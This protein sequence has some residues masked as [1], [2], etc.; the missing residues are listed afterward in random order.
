MPRLLIINADDLGY[1]PAVTTGILEAM[2]RGVVSSATLM[3][4]SPSSADAAHRARGRAVGL[5]LNLARWAPCWPGFPPGLLSNGE[6]DEANA[7]KLSAAVAE[8]ETLAQLDRFEAL[9]GA[10]PTHVDVH[11]HLHLHPAVFEGLC[12]AARLRALPVRSLDAAMRTRLRERQVRTCDAFIGEASAGGEAYWTLNRL[13]EQLS[14][15]SGDG[16]T[17]LMCHPGYAPATVKSGYSAQ[18]EV[19]LETFLHPGARAL[20]AHLGFTLEG[21]GALP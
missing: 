7:G 21:Y 12:A 20:I 4:N 19:E 1:D 16:C 2:D 13:R 17:E 14:A 10:P 5:H 11:K 18:R 3:V 6:L 15:L 9:F 8:G